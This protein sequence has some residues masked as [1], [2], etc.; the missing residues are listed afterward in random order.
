MTDMKHWPTFNSNRRLS[1]CIIMENNVV[2]INRF[3]K[4][5]T[6]EFMIHFSSIYGLINDG[7][8]LLLKFERIELKGNKKAV[9]MRAH[10]A[11][12]RNAIPERRWSH[13]H[14]LYGMI[15]IHLYRKRQP[16]K[17]WMM[18]EMMTSS[19]HISS[20]MSWG[21]HPKVKKINVPTAQT[22]HMREKVKAMFNLFQY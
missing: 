19:W 2:C 16:K 9:M 11:Q 6:K 14:R 18:C 3:H 17:V 22:L 8:I 10:N 15:W 20:Y 13:V 21:C 1:T 12:R 7:F 4:S 5:N